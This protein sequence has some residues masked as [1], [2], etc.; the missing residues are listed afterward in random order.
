M[1]GHSKWANIKHRKERVDAKRGKIFTRLI[2]E[3]TVAAKL[4]GDEV[5]ANP[6]LRLALEKAKEVNMPNDNISRAIKRG[7]GQLDGGAVNYSEVTYEGYGV[8]G[9]AVLVSCL[10]DNKNRTFPEVRH[11]F[12]KHGGNLGTT[13]SVLY[14]FNRLGQLLFEQPKQPEA[15]IDL[16]IE[17]GA[18]DVNEEDGNI[19]ILCSPDKLID[20]K[21]ILE[22]NEYSPD[23]TDVL[24]KAE[25]EIT[26]QGDDAAQMQ[27]LLDALENLDDTQQVATNAVLEGLP[28]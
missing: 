4:G 28:S 7:C 8:G 21:S 1:A 25:S 16:A 14:L 27:K 26:L 20:L 23:V 6:R 10:T 17:N 12:G 15:L 22:Q 2:R 5:A 19:E 18:D 11:T 9:A 3:I 24:M 13:G